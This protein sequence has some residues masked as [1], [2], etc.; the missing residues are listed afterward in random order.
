M[1][2]DPANQTD[3]IREPVTDELIPQIA[4]I[5]RLFFAYRDFTADAD[6][7]L[8]EFDYGRAHHRTLY[9]VNRRPGMTVAE[10]IAILG[11]TKQSLSR[12]LRQL[13]Q[14]GHISQVEGRT[15]RRQRLLYPT[16]AGR[17]L[18]MRLSKPQSVRI[19]RAL[20]SCGLQHSAAIADFLH[21]MADRPDELL[22]NNRSTPSGE[23]E[24]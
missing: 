21:A 19:A 8:H 2:A 4:I 23:S 24:E 11:I 12:V 22:T 17:S 14:S 5:E 18:L 13:I 10:L 1:T 15:D 20:R 6:R 16:Q 7:I 3:L 9:F